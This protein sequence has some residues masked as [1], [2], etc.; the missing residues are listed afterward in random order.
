V[1]DETYLE[2]GK[3]QGSKMFWAGAFGMNNAIQQSTK[4]AIDKILVRALTDMMSRNI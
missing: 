4:N 3:S 1:F 2:K